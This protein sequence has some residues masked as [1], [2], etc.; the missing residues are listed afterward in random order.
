MIIPLI[1]LP[2]LTPWIVVGFIW[3][4]GIDAQAGLWG[5]MLAAIGLVPDL[6]SVLWAWA[7]IIAMD[8]WHW[9]SFVVIL[10]YAGYLSIPQA[11]FR[12]H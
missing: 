4:H 7:T 10:C 1:A 8:V 2:L 3:R 11:Y 12:L 6:N 5:T 9:T